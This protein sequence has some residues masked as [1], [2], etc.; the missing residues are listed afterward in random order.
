[1]L[2]LTPPLCL[3]CISEGMGNSTMLGSASSRQLIWHNPL[4]LTNSQFLICKMGIMLICT[5]RVVKR[6]KWHGPMWC[7][8]RIDVRHGAFP[9]QPSRL[10]LCKEQAFTQVKDGTWLRTNRC[11]LFFSAHLPKCLAGDVPFLG[12]LSTSLSGSRSLKPQR[13]T[14]VFHLY[15]ITCLRFLLPPHMSPPPVW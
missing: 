15:R 9:D 8:V 6:N 5:Y 13:T 3:T 14:Y 1:M 11:S 2:F 12:P 7:A 10:S 4:R